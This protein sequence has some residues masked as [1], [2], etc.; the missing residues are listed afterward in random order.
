MSA[1]QRLT[2]REVL[3]TASLLG[4]SAA[5]LAKPDA[6]SAAEGGA[7]LLP[8]SGLVTRQPKPLQVR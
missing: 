3:Q 7:A 6:A 8:E 2:R 4:I 5:V 1:R